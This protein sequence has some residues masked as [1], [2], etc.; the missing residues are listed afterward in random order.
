MCKSKEND[1]IFFDLNF[2]R[3]VLYQL[4]ECAIKWSNEIWAIFS[5]VAMDM[6]KCFNGWNT[7]I[8]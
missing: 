3:I 2:V 6:T 8:K 7:L 1:K 4:K 5:R